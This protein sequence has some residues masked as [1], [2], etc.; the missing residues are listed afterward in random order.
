M[1]PDGHLIPIVEGDQGEGW[2]DIIDLDEF[3]NPELDRI[4]DKREK[5]SRR[6]M[7]RKL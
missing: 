5:F 7:I 6:K 1:T 4:L 3:G 2:K